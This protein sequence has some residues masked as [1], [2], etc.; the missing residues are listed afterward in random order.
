MSG[1]AG[2]RPTPGLEDA[3]HFI[4]PV[5]APIWWG[6]KR[7]VPE[8]L[9]DRFWRLFE[10]WRFYRIGAGWPESGTWADQGAEI[11]ESVLRFEEYYRAYFSDSIALI[12]I[13][14]QVGIML[15]KRGA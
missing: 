1:S 8:L 14:K 11:A 15:A 6:K 12:E 3:D 5:K 13:L 7:E 4:G 2:Y 10:V 9:T